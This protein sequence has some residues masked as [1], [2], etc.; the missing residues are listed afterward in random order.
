MAFAGA[1][2][3]IAQYLTDKQGHK[4]YKQ[5]AFAGS[6]SVRDAR[7]KIGQTV[8]VGTDQVFRL[9]AELALYKHSVASS[10]VHTGI[11]RQASRNLNKSML[12]A[13]AAGRPEN[14]EEA[15][16]AGGGR[17]TNGDLG[18]I[19]RT[20]PRRPPWEGPHAFYAA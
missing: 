1:G 14:V 9:S 17:R 2:T 19:R 10:L 3:E 5:Q 11:Q 6:S 7:H 20:Q 12:S 16:R 15:R 18:R 8:Y 13:T 4:H